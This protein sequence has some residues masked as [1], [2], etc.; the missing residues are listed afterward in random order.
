MSYHLLTEQSGKWRF[1][2]RVHEMY[3]HEVVEQIELMYPDG[4][5]FEVFKGEIC[6]LGGKFEVY[7]VVCALGVTYFS[8]GEIVL[9]RALCHYRWEVVPPRPGV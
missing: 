4:T 1:Q 9:A 6:M 3:P 5:T 7:K 2:Q 8:E